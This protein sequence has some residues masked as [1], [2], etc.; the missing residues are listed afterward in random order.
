[1]KKSIFLLMLLASA[2]FLSATSFETLYGEFVQI[3]SMQDSGRMAEFIKKVETEDLN[4]V[5]T[6]TLLADS[7]RE[8]ANWEEDKKTRESHYK[9]ARELAEKAIEI[10]PSYGMAYYV[11]GASI[12]QLAQMVGI[13]QSIFLI[14]EFDKSIDKAME[15]MPDSPFPF[16]AKG[17]RDRDTPWPYKNY[18]KSEE[19]FLRAIENDPLY[20]NSYYE[21]AVLYDIWKKKDLAAQYYRK[22][23]ELELNPD[24]IAQGEESKETAREW[25]ANNGY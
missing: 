25:L 9:S 5:K 1:M 16:I 11:K 17:M 24:F 10:D 12:G 20:I 15:L 3:R 23:L 2:V 19:R 21:L 14:S 8:Y 13:I 22:V 18:K 4:D 6:L 7:H